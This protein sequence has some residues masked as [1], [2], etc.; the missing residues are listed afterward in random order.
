V[1]NIIILIVIAAITAAFM[2]HNTQVQQRL[3][4]IEEIIGLSAKTN[5]E[6]QSK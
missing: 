3:K 4:R 5:T 1:K 2:V 6:N